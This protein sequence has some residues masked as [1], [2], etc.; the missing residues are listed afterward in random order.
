MGLCGKY[1]ASRKFTYLVMS[2]FSKRMC[3]HSVVGAC[4]VRSAARK[5]YGHG[6]TS[7]LIVGMLL[8]LFCLF[9][10]TPASYVL[11]DGGLHWS[12]TSVVHCK[13]RMPGKSM[14]PCSLIPLTATGVC[15]SSS[16]SSSTTRS[17]CCSCSSEG[18]CNIGPH[19][20]V[21]LLLHVCVGV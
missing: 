14:Y 8:L 3:S 19:R 6:C 12:S 10:S 11:I 18:G 5:H 17:C 16:S 15:S 13:C 4:L 9:A 21:P 20:P 7:Q 1:L 2:V